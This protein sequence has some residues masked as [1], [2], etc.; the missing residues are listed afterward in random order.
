MYYGIV[1]GAVAGGAAGGVLTWGTDKVVAQTKSKKMMEGV[2]KQVLDRIV[3]FL[4]M[5]KDTNAGLSNVRSSIERVSYLRN[6]VT[7]PTWSPDVL[8]QPE[9]LH[10]RRE[11]IHAIEDCIDTGVQRGATPLFIG[12]IIKR[13][14]GLISVV[15]AMITDIMTVSRARLLHRPTP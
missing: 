14:Q 10:L 1:L 6:E 13:K 9:A 8:V 12:E 4:E 3:S 2:P 7:D 5:F 15:G 11:C